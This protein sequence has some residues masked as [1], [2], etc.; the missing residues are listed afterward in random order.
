MKGYRF[1]LEYPNS[2]E[3]KKA[4]VKNL[5]NHKGNV[6]AVSFQDYRILHFEKDIQYDS[7]CAGTDHRNGYVVSGTC[8]EGYL[9]AVCK[10]IPEN[11]ARIIHPRLF[12]VLDYNP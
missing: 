4:T 12:A 5:G 1:Y 9:R 2:T 8:T 3:K 10:R 6:V 7:F 11:L